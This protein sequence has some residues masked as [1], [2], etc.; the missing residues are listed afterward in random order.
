M[1][2]YLLCKA[3]FFNSLGVIK[4]YCKGDNIGINV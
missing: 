2:L 3:I 1:L 4:L